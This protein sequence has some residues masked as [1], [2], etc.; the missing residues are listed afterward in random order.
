VFASSATSSLSCWLASGLGARLEALAKAEKQGIP[1]P[2]KELA[3]IRKAIMA[4]PE[5]PTG[6]VDKKYTS[7]LA[8][9]TKD[10][11]TKKAAYDSRNAESSKITRDLVDLGRK[12]R[13]GG[14]H[15][16]EEQALA[17]RLEA[18]DKELSAQYDGHRKA[19]FD[20]S[21]ALNKHEQDG[22]TKGG[23]ESFWKLLEG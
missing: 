14:K 23:G 6:S 7:T 11:D 21:G 18:R 22:W 2:A 19:Y 16:P 8:K 17:D 13:F 20:A 3:E 9:L 15:T 4:V 1:V 10:H 5:L 12:L